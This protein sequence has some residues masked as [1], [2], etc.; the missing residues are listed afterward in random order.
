MPGDKAA[1]TRKV[2]VRYMLVLGSA[3]AAR[4]EMLDRLLR[5][6]ADDDPWTLVNAMRSEGI[7]LTTQAHDTE[8]LSMPKRPGASPDGLL[9]DIL[10]DIAEGAASEVLMNGASPDWTLALV[11]SDHPR[12]D[13]PHGGTQILGRAYGLLGGQNRF[14]TRFG[15]IV[16][17]NKIAEEVPDLGPGIDEVEALRRV[18]L[19][20]I[21]HE[22]GHLLNLPH[23]WE[24]ERGFRILGGPAPDLDSYMNYASS[25]PFGSASSSHY[26]DIQEPPK[27]ARRSA[28]RLRY[29]NQV[30]L[31]GSIRTRG[32]DEAERAF[33]SHAPFDQ[34]AQGGRTFLDA[35]LPEPAF[36]PPSQ[37]TPRLEIG[38][39][40]AGAFHPVELI[41]LWHWRSRDRSTV[42]FPPIP[43]LVRFTPPPGSAISDD[44]RFESGA[45]Q[46]L[47]RPFY[48]DQRPAHEPA[49]RT[50][51]FDP[52]RSLELV[53]PIVQ[54][55]NEVL[56]PWMTL[57]DVMAYYLDNPVVFDLQVVY[58][59]DSDTSHAS[60]I[61]RVSFQEPRTH[62]ASSREFRR[63]VE[64]LNLQALQ[65]DAGG[66]VP[67][68]RPLPAPEGIVAS[69]DIENPFKGV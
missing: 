38:S 52:S 13:M 49:P 21:M 27:E 56:L 69:I 62:P 44:F 18:I 37:G 65:A 35:I 4:T 67:K 10:V 14:R 12:K 54:R 29:F 58:F 8:S 31:S 6:P 33:I 1:L 51:A 50:V 42:C 40:S 36:L 23:C 34:I 46:L 66:D 2:H 45:L 64:E 24:R 47:I 41:E 28:Q 22:L 19:H 3:D 5:Q 39:R 55:P 7:E 11:L 61:V 57:D 48:G 17:I 25:W 15:A 16:H 20:H 60:N 26:A 43:A 30:G 32:F 59:R 68:G 63:L 9:E 53:R